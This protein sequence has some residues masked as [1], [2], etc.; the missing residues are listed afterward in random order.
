Q[1]VVPDTYGRVDLSGRPDP[2]NTSAYA[3]T[4]VYS[5]DE[6][7]IM[8]H[9]GGVQRLRV[10]LNGNLVHETAGPIDWL[11][12][13]DRVPVTLRN[14][15]NTLLMRVTK[16]DGGHQFILRLGDDPASQGFA[17]A[18]MGLWKEAVEAWKPLFA[19]ELPDPWLWSVCG[20]AL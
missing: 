11:W 4:Y 13:T 5:P 8:L 20:Q 15:R 6:R 17:L 12:G 2:Q 18:E 3:L 9:V 16:T 1:H 10:W 19:R 7:T 14:G